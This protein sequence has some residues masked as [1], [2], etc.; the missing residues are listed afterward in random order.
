MINAAEVEVESI[1]C[2]LLAKALEGKNIKELLLNVGSGGG[3][4]AVGSGAPTA[5]S[6]GPAPDTA[7]APK[8]E[9]KEVEESDDDMVCALFDFNF[10]EY[11]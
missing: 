3:A 7:E 6:S 10:S 4:P 11:H 1:W 2:S 5:S 8:E 9:A